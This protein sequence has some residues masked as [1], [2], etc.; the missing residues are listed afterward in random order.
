MKPLAGIW[1]IALI[2]WPALAVDKITEVTIDGKN[3]SQIQDAHIVN[4]GKVV[5]LYPGGGTTVAADKLSQ[6]FLDSWGIKEQDLASA[7]KAKEQESQQAFEQAVRAGLFREVEGVVYD[8][9]KSQ[10]QWV[11]FAGAKVLQIVDNGAL[12]DPTPKEPVVTFV[13]VHN[14]PNTLSDSDTVSVW[15]KLTGHVT[16]L[17]KSGFPRTIRAYDAGRA[18]GRDEIPDVMWKQGLAQ[19]NLVESFTPK[20]RTVSVLPDQEHLRSTG[21]GFFITEDGYLLTNFH[22]VANAKTVKV[23]YKDKGGLLTAT[24]VEV[25]REN[26]LAVLK[27]DGHY[28]PLFISRK[29]SVDLGESVFT[30]GFPNFDVQ[31]LEPKFTDGKI[32]SLTG[33]QDDSRDYQISVPVQPGNSGG[34]LCNARGEVVGIVV[35]RLNDMAVLRSSGS[36]PQ[37]VN[38][39]VKAKNA[40]NLLEK[41]VPSASLPKANNAIS[42]TGVVQ[43][44]EDSIAMILIY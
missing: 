29:G 30:I 1:L 16:Y 13:M 23:K 40:L 11:R 31:G 7:K 27:V 26:D 10:A 8:L 34:P 15:A 2:A 24:V 39:A 32:S 28:K 41:A 5:I 20:S 17:T 42:S 38:Y 9:R 43:S 37:D 44:V 19:A 4:G 22:V 21:S 6:K 12:L 14:L 33:I 36:L 25:D 3:Y 35:A 18:C